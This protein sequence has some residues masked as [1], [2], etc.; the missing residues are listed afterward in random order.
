MTAATRGVLVRGQDPMATLGALPDPPAPGTATYPLETCSPA[1][2][3][4]PGSK[5]GSRLPPRDCRKHHT[6]STPPGLQLF[7]P[8]LLSPSLSGFRT[9]KS[10]LDSKTP[11]D[12][13]G[14]LRKLR[15][16][17]ASSVCN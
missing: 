6:P 11:S 17:P 3:H 10:T 8:P 1:P 5:Y 4:T 2:T 13:W 14:Q 16:S 9:N 12:G 7:S 15:W